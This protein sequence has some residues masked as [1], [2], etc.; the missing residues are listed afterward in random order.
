MLGTHKVRDAVTQVWH[1]YEGPVD[2]LTAAEVPGVR[3][4]KPYL[5]SPDG[6]CEHLRPKG[7]PPTTARVRVAAKLSL[8][9]DQ[10]LEREATHYQQFPDH[11]FQHWSGY[12]AT[13]PSHDPFPMDALVPQ[14]YGYYKPEEDDSRKY[15]SPI[16][17]LEDCGQ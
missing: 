5:S 4:Q 16:L 15:L 7:D 2:I 14:F 13:P 17:L 6:V 11:F 9:E 12:G 3:L 1:T 10:H 8:S